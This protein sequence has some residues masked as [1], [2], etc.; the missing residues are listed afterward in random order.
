[1]RSARCIL[2]L[3]FLWAPAAQ[4]AAAPFPCKPCAGLRLEPAPPQ[5][6]QPTEPNGMPTPPTPE[7]APATPPPPPAPPVLATPTDLAPVLRQIG[8]ME[9]G[10]PL[11][12]ASEAV[13]G[14]ADPATAAASLQAV[15]EA[16]GTPWISL[17]FRTP[18][19]LAQGS[20]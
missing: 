9:P 3:L 14:E 17:V 15:R 18:A 2:L 8:R 19:P 13:L 12:V 10:S 4:L 5:A 11:Y 7:T 1:M 16:G 20:D 6:P